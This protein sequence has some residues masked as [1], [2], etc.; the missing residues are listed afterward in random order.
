MATLGALGV[1]TGLVACGSDQDPTFNAGSTTTKPAN[2]V[3]TTLAPNVKVFS[4][5]VINNKVEGGPQ[6]AEVKLGEQVRIE[7]TSDSNDEV[8]VHGYDLTGAIEAG[9][10][11]RIDLVANQAGQWEIELHD[12]KTLLATLKVSP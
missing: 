1:A 2:G 11:T 5:N 9:V 12:G 8:H 10:T 3:T 7:V 6:T 4:I